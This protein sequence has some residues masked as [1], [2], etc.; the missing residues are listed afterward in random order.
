MSLRGA[1]SAGRAHLDAVAPAR[2][3]PCSE[4]PTLTMA[5]CLCPT[6]TASVARRRCPPAK[7]YHGGPS[8]PPAA[9]PRT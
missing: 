7:Q 5:S 3:T 9:T 2:R 1:H 8:L 4:G 6:P